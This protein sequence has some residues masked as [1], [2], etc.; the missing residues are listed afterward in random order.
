MYKIKQYSI[1]FV[2]LITI[3]LSACTTTPTSTTT[4]LKTYPSLENK[5]SKIKRIMV[6][7]PDVAIEKITITGNNERLPELEQSIKAQLVNL[8][9]NNINQHNFE[10]IDFDFT[11]SLK[12][13]HS[14]AL[15]LDQVKAR[16]SQSK[17]ERQAE[18][19]IDKKDR[20]I[21]KISV[22]SMI[23]TI[24]EATESDAIL[25]INF[26]GFKKSGVK[27]TQ[28]VISSALLGLTLGIMYAPVQY[29]SVV[30]I[31]LLDA[32]TGDL[33][34]ANSSKNLTLDSKTSFNK[35]IEKFPDNV[36]FDNKLEESH[37]DKDLTVKVE[38]LKTAL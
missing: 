35:A 16:F 33:I 18:K 1:F 34:W 22:G 19:K 20:N 28:E 5:F 14:L 27:M 37:D 32:I 17:R 24:T 11:S 13:N 4:P 31:Y 38:G 9:Q 26:T 10:F 36:N 7:P 6:T 8:A 23:N 25:M 30:E 3:F 29:T 15:S 21:T 2:I 12:N